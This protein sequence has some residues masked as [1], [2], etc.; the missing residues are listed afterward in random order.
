MVWVCQRVKLLALVMRPRKLPNHSVNNKPSV[1]ALTRFT[2]MQPLQVM[3][4]WSSR[5]KSLLAVVERVTL[6]TVSRVVFA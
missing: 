2:E 6:T 5:P 4:I 3:M 1:N